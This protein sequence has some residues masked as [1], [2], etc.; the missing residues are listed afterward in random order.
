MVFFLKSKNK[1]KDNFE[2]GFL[3]RI[4][5]TFLFFLTLFGI[6]TYRL[7]TLQVINYGHYHNLANKQHQYKKEIFPKRGDI[8]LQ[9]KNGEL[10]T[11][12]TDRD[13]KTVF[14]IPLEISEEEV[15]VLSKQLAEILGLDEAEVK[16][17]ISKE[18][19]P[20][21]ILKRKLSEEEVVKINN[22]NAKGIYLEDES[23]RF[24]PG[25]DLAAHA[26]GFVSYPNSK[27]SGQYGIEREF[28]K[29]LSGR[30][31]LLEEEKDTFGHWISLGK[32]NLTPAQDGSNLVLTI[33]HAIQFRAQ[34][35]LKNAVSRHGAISGKIIVI[36]PQ[37]GKILALAAEPTFNLNEYSKVED[38]DVF[39][40]PI[41]SKEYECGSV[42]KAITM[43][44]GLD[45]AKIKSNTTYYDSGV[46]SEAGYEIKNSD[47]KAYGQ[48]TMTEALEKSLNT[49]MIFA[50][51]QMGH[52]IFL[53][54]IKDFG[55]GT[56]TGITLPGEI[57]GNLSNLDS[58]RAIEFYTASFGQGITVTPIQL[59]MA[60]GAMANG[61]E[62]LKPRIVDYSIDYNGGKRYSEKEVIRNVISSD[63]AREVTQMLE[64]NVINGHGKRA[65]VPGYRIVGKTGTAQM[66]D[67]VKGGYI[68]GATVGSFAGYG[69]VE[70]PAFAMLVVI[71]RP[72]GVSWAESTAAP[73]FGEMA[74]FILS[75]KGIEPTETYTEDDLR[76]FTEMHSYIPKDK[77][78]STSSGT[79]DEA[80]SPVKHQGGAKKAKNKKNKKD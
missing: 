56:K 19:D 44:A 40:D 29:L 55:F 65:R 41:I 9:E 45:S 14:A 50:E 32:K 34:L 47:G 46:V 70:D 30:S 62:L 39:L 28:N 59:A 2:R 8:F 54:Y 37:T 31:G 3:L 27:A 57:T 1:D 67:K 26:L 69:P 42:F 66:S 13:L 25:G 61:G 10:F 43:A 52:E 78:L 4:N 64:S 63:S 79:A 75:Y 7:Y 22:L 38:I 12:A 51:K 49:G 68:E 21:E 15:S 33:D 11:A 5:L 18:N 76:K 60:Y 80:S 72:Q 53:R 36:E 48:Q 23:W 74:K 77:D 35:A 17:K 58:R 24:Y 6:V 71:E 16:S 20:H 73:V